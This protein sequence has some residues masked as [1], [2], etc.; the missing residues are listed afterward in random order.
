MY[1]ICFK[2]FRKFDLLDNFEIKNINFLVGKNNSGKSTL[3][4]GL[5]LYLENIQSLALSDCFIG[6]DKICQPLFK[7]NSNKIYDYHIGTFGRAKN[8]KSKEDFIIFGL[9]IDNLYVETTVSRRSKNIKKESGSVKDHYNS[10][11][12]PISKIVFSE[13]NFDVR[14]TLDFEKQKFKI[15]YG[16]LSIF[17]EGTKEKLDIVVNPFSNDD[18]EI[19]NVVSVRNKVLSYPFNIELPLEYEILSK[20]YDYLSEGK[21][22]PSLIS[23]FNKVSSDKYN[24]RPEEIDYFVNCVD[25]IQSEFNQSYIKERIIYIPSHAITRSVVYN[26]SDKNDF[27]ASAIAEYLNANIK[28]RSPE[29]KFITDWMDEKHFNIG[30]DFK[31]EHFGGES[32]R[33]E[34][35]DNKKTTLVPL[36]DKGVGSN[37]LMI[38]LLQFASIIKQ[39]KNVEKKPIVIIEEPEQNLHPQFQSMLAKLFLN[40]V[41]MT[42]TQ[43]SIPFIVETHSEYTIRKT[44]VLIK[45]LAKDVNLQNEDELEENSPFTVYYFDK[46]NANEPFYKMIYQKNGLFANEFGEG[47]IDESTTLLYEVLKP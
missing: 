28:P 42:G 39:Y 46:D 26:T 40:V 5:I 1:K 9:H 38:M 16:I 2:N 17:D 31:I 24:S 30:E 41:N 12:A 14:I 6:N 18:S 13:K 33:L 27:M 45:D 21:L 29:Y 11:E 25:R 22:Y 19:M 10:T 32:F 20:T 15:E 47:F 8:N 3:T 37:Q 4:K 7:F 34:I 43:S 44:Q 36:L 35:F 23:Y